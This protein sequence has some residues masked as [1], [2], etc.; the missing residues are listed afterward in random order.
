MDNE[1]FVKDIKDWEW[2]W[3]NKR[4]D[5]PVIIM[6]NPVDIVKTIYEKYR[7]VIQAAY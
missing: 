2:Q 7:S 6:G 5:Y 1:N 4:T 3:V